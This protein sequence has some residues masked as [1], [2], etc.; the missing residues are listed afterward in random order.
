MNNSKDNNLIFGRNPVKEA[1]RA[2][3]VLKVF[4]VNNFSDKEINLLLQEKKPPIKVVSSTEMDSMVHGVHQGIVASVKPYEYSDLDEILR[5]SRK[6]EVPIIV[7]L[8]GI[9][10]THNLGAIL[11]SCDVF[12]VTGVLIPK[13]NQVPLNAT[14]AKSSAGAI[15]FVPVAQIGS[16]NQTLQRLKDNGFWIVSTDGGA[17]IDYHQITYDFPVALVIGSE[18]KGVSPLV[19]KNSDYVVKIPQY[20][21]V[22]SL[23]ASVA[24]GILLAKIRN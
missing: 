7:I 3:K 9:N 5:R 22:N 12:N 18:G 24:A 2:N 21:H 4:V 19:I 23:N 20:G 1:L 13:H 14:V 16:I 8:D 15:N 10:D 11:R 6:V 17:K